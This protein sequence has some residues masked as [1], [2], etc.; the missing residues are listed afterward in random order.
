MF[1]LDAVPAMPN[2]AT[3][4]TV[5]PEV[6]GW[7]FFVRDEETVHNLF[8]HCKFTQGVWMALFCSV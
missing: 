5:D 7:L 3:G 4:P 2:K 1:A 8:V 6:F